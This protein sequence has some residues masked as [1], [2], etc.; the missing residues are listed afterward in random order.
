[1]PGGHWAALGQPL[2][3]G[4]DS[5][6]APVLA[7]WAAANSSQSQS[8]LLS[9]STSGFHLPGEFTG[10]MPQWETPHLP[11]APHLLKVRPEKDFWPHA[12]SSQRVV[13]MAAC[14]D[15]PEERGG[16][17]CPSSCPRVAGQE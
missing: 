14:P 6:V 12:M 15:G 4:K 8:S 1:M 13:T 2:L 9:C 16:S 7:A 17:S 10:K 5:L 11:L 3:L